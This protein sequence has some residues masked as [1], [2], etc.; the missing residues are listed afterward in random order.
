MT[1]YV[2]VNVLHNLIEV[3]QSGYT[4]VQGLQGIQGPKSQLN[5]YSDVI[6]NIPS[7]SSNGD[8]F[9]ATDTK[10]LLIYTPNGWYLIATEPFI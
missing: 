2:S 3:S 4:G 10:Q 1:D 6:G 7:T 9:Y 8:Y 5:F